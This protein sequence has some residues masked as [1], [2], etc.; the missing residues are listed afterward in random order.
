M[1][2]IVKFITSKAGVFFLLVVFLIGGFWFVRHKIIETKVEKLSES[3]YAKLIECAELCVFKYEYWELVTVTHTVG[4]LWWK[5]ESQSNVKYK[6][7][8]R[9]GISNMREIKFKI[10]QGGKIITI[11]LPAIKILGNGITDQEV[12][13]ENNGAIAPDITIEEMTEEIE[14][15]KS[16]KL[17]EL[18]STDFLE[19]SE[20]QV[21]QVLKET[22]I[23]MGFE[24]VIF[25]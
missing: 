15:S 5:S 6:A 22:F 13:S 18:E 2:T 14:K 4:I 3:I 25:K 8:V 9:A 10:S 21:Q 23:G 17:K 20:E 1:K 12:L 24:Q 11:N 16:K 19:R 7:V